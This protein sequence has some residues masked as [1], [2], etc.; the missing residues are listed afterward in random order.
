MRL[1]GTCILEVDHALQ[2]V[3][4]RAAMAAGKVGAIVHAHVQRQLLVF[5]LCILFWVVASIGV[6]P[7]GCLVEG[8][9]C[10]LVEVTV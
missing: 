1:S 2:D 4:R 5:L 3:A 10:L 8:L 7:I 6:E 9:L